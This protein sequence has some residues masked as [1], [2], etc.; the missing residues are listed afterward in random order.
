[1][2]TA[3]ETA[4]TPTSKLRT[5]TGS[6]GATIPKPIA[7]MNAATTRIQIWRGRCSRSRAGAR[8]PCASTTGDL[9]C[10]AIEGLYG[11]RT[12][13]SPVG[14]SGSGHSDRLREVGQLGRGGVAA[15]AD[16]HHRA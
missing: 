6:V 14:N 9:H 3:S 11:G 1:M 15:G 8:R 13:I 4:V 16:D 2:L 7:I 12:P 5:N 10:I